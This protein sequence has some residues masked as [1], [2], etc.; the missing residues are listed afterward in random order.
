MAEKHKD[1]RQKSGKFKNGSDNNGD[2]LAN[3]RGTILR[4]VQI[5][6]VF[7]ILFSFDLKRDTGSGF[8]RRNELPTKSS[9]RWKKR[10]LRKTG[11]DTFPSTEADTKGFVSSLLLCVCCCCCCFYL[12][13]LFL[14]LCFDSA[15]GNI[16]ARKPVVRFIFTAR[17][18]RKRFHTVRLNANW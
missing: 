8:S 5:S 3:E 9:N 1:A 11:W 7:I 14:F 15:L 12:P 10:S 13:G 6:A 17:R 16:G 18:M 2:E 4:D